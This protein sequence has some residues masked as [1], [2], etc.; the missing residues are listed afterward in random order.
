MGD[1]AQVLIHDGDADDGVFLY[2][3][4]SGSQLHTVV[5][6]A[7]QRHWRW[8]DACYLGRVVFQEMIGGDN[9]KAQETGFGIDNIEHGDLEHRV[10]V[11]NTSDQSV[12]WRP[13]GLLPHEQRRRWDMSRYVE[14]S[15]T[16]LDKLWA[17]G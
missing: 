11:L 6:T 17:E 16:V 5:Q 10:I 15:A 9:A 2:T 3:H 1:R 4:W 8:N 7:L 13:C 14:E 12:E